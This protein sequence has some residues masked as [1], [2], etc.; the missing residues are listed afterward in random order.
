M[1]FRFRA[2]NYQ[3]RYTLFLCTCK[4]ITEGTAAELKGRKRHSKCNTVSQDANTGQ[5]GEGEEREKK[6]EVKEPKGRDNR[7]K[8]I[9][10]VSVLLQEIHS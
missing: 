4:T 1:N 9:L 8:K 7:K 3:Q 10:I 5:W 6:F 2:E